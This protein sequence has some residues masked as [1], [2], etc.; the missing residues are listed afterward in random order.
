MRI[1]ITESERKPVGTSQWSVTLDSKTDDEGT[2]EAVALALR[3][4][5]AYGHHPK[6]V[7]DSA[8]CESNEQL[9]S[10]KEKDE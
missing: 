6:N 1:Y 9:H 10:L 8:I 7:Y 2:E 4:V 5:V 3:A